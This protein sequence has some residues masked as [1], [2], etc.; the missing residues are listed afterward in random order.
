MNIQCIVPHGVRTSIGHLQKVPLR[1]LA[2]PLLHTPGS[3]WDFPFGRVVA[4]SPQALLICE[5]TPCSHQAESNTNH[6]FTNDVFSS[7]SSRF[8]FCHFSCLLKYLVNTWEAYV[9]RCQKSLQLQRRHSHPSIAP[10]VV[11][12][13]ISLCFSAAVPRSAVE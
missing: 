9:N 11:R 12:N 6:A 1:A 10:Q 5:P 2:E 8:L 4:A 3:T 7:Q 13:P